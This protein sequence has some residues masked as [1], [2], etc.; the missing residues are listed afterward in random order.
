[1]KVTRRQLKSIIKEFL[2]T[3]V[4]PAAQATSAYDQATNSERAAFISA[5]TS[6]FG[7]CIVSPCVD[8]QLLD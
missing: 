8:Y 3:S 6:G 5:I 1:M 7:V 4:K 2:D